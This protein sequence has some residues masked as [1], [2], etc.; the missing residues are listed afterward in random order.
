ML[1]GP[2]AF[3][4]RGTAVQ[5]AVAL[6]AGLHDVAMVG[7]PV[8]QGRGHL[9]VSEDGRPLVRQSLGR[10]LRELLDD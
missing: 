4:R 3:L 5:E 1:P 6:V 9:G 7:Q 10:R 8:E 2:D